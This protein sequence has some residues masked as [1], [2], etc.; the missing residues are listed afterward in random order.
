[1]DSIEKQIETYKPFDEVEARDKAYF[2]AIMERYKN[3]DIFSRQNDL[4]HFTSSALAVNEDL[5]KMLCV[6]H[7]IFGGYVYPGGHADGD[8]NMLGVSIRET[9]E[10]AFD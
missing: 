7:N 1:M 2:L 9:E 10:E 5:D 4:V 6:Y 3:E 8:R